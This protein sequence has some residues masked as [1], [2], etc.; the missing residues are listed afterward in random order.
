[1][2][3]RARLFA[4]VEFLRGRRSGVTAEALAQR[5]NVTVRTVYRDLDTLREAALPLKAD[6]GRGGGFALDRHY[7]LPPVNFTAREA[8]TLLT[9][10]RWAMELR[11]IPFLDTC[12]SGLDKVQGALSSSAQWELA[13]LMQ[14]M[15]F[16]GV[17]ALPIDPAVRQAIETAWF[18]QQPVT[19]RYDG[20]RGVTTRTIRIERIVLERSL[21]FLNAV[22]LETGDSRQFR[23]DRVT[24]AAVGRSPS[25]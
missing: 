19:I 12:A 15:S 11:L 21:T 13:A 3:R 7:T 23:L 5:F 24:M 20:V 17:P 6:R 25:P 9:V 8:A 16:T 10:G 2:T 18:E 22:D 4:M 1:M 14:R